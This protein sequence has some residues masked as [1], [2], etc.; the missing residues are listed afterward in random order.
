VT[1]TL[2]I[3][4]VPTAITLLILGIVLGGCGDSRRSVTAPPSP[5]PTSNA[6]YAVPLGVSQPVMVASTFGPGQNDVRVTITVFQVRD[7]VAPNAPP[8]PQLGSHWASADVQVCRTAPVILGYPAWILDDDSGRTAHADV[9]GG[10]SPGSRRTICI[11]QRS[12]S[13]SPALSLAPGESGSETW[14][15]EIL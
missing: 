1:T 4:G 12:L 5:A 9:R 7:R 3:R 8:P 6:P 2:R 13:N 10:G 11:R 14:V 15:A